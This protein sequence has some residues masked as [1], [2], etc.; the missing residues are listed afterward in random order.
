MTRIPRVFHQIWLGSKEM[1]NEF[2]RFGASWIEKH[3]GWEFRLWTDSNLPPLRNQLLFDAAPSLAAK[4]DI[5]RYEVLLEHGGV[6]IDTDFECLRSVEGLLE[7]VDCFVGQQHDIDADF[8]RFCY[9]NNA[10]IGAIP[11]HPLIAEL[12]SSLEA[13][14]AALRPDVPASYMTGPHFLTS[15]LQAYPDVRIFPAKFFYPYTATERWRRFEKFPEAYAV[16]HWTLSDLAVS[17]N[18]PRQIASKRL[19]CLSVAI[20]S[21][22]ETDT[23][24]LRWVLEG[25]CLQSINNFEVLAIF[26]GEAVLSKEKFANMCE[27]L[28]VNFLDSSST[29]MSSARNLALD[30][31]QSDRVLFLDSDS[32][33]DPDV[34]ETHA[35]QGA[36]SVLAFSYR[37]IYPHGKF[38]SFRDAVDYGG[39]MKHCAPERRNLYVTP[40]RDRWKDVG[41]YCFS[42]PTRLA[43]SQGGFRESDNGDEVSELAH[44]LSENGCPSV[45]C[46]YGARVTHFCSQ[47]ARSAK[48][49]AVSGDVLLRFNDS[50]AEIRKSEFGDGRDKDGRLPFILHVAS[51][52]GERRMPITALAYNLLAEFREPSP[53]KETVLRVA[54]RVS[55][56]INKRERVIG[57]C[58]QYIEQFCAAG[59]LALDGGETKKA[60]KGAG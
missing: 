46:V 31:A 54:E 17:R 21:N 12:V 37:R 22:R 40:S 35:R 33:P 51:L 58:M 25:L 53:P 44:R 49:A 57:L 9:V 30:T 24:R 23:E 26:D 14:V 6:Y 27:K 8:G 45:P 59:I 47:S 36:N 3:P 7:G 60:A 34:V 15:V 32:L 2:R 55:I 20:V 19:Y 56:E 29:G 38:F 50:I 11:G 4:A 13:H 10:L 18:K 16:H 42:V 41:S 1:P 28:K 48:S 43:K 39:I 52:A 5:L